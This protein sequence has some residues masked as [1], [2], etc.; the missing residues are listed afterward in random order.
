MQLVAGMAEVAWL[1]SAGRERVSAGGG[2]AGAG[3]VRGDELVEGV[4]CSGEFWGGQEGRGRAPVLRPAGSGWTILLSAA[5]INGE[6]CLLNVVSG[7]P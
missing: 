6:W 5:R 1:L 7:D 3:E 2:D 4:E